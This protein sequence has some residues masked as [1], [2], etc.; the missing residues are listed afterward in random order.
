MIRNYDLIYV[1]QQVTFNLFLSIEH[2]LSNMYHPVYK[3]KK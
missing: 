2:M 3:T 1:I